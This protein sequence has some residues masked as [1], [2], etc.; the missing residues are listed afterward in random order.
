MAALDILWYGA[1]AMQQ[2][3]LPILVNGRRFHAPTITTLLI[4]FAA[5]AAGGCDPATPSSAPSRAPK[6]NDGVKLTLSCP[7]A[8]FAEAIEPMVRSW[9]AR[10]GAAVALSREPMKPD[11]ATDLAV[12]PAGAL[13][14]WA[15][16][17]QLAP[18]PPRLRNQVSDLL[19]PYAERLAAW[20]DQ[21]QAVP[22]T[23]DGVVLVFRADRFADPATAAEFQARAKRPLAPPATWDQFAA[24]A[25]FFAER[26]KKPSLPPLPADP[27]RLFDLVSRVAASSDRAAL[28]DKDLAERVKD[29]ELLAFHFSVKTGKPRLQSPGFAAAAKWLNALAAT[30]CLPPGASDDPAAA[31]G[32]GRAV[33]AVFSLDQ[34]AKLPRE[35]GAVPARFGIA[36][37]PGAIWG[38]EAGAKPKDDK[39]TVNYVP[40]FAGGRLGVVRAKCPHPEAAFDL[41]AEI[42][43]PA[44]SAELISTPGLGAGPLRPADLGPDL[45]PLWLG[46]G[47]D[48]ARSRALQ[49]ALRHYLSDT[50]KNPAFGLRGPDRDA[51]TLAASDAFR[52][53]GTGAKPT[54]VLGEAQLVWGSLDAK[55][56]D[57]AT[58]LRWRKRAAG[59]N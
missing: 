37:L 24:V 26:D 16:P 38:A 39:E 21:T 45:F 5:S 17:G 50:V 32:E 54:D 55:A 12:I 52:K 2:A 36:V 48:A 34:L 41:L 27:A 44:R 53:L 4:A 18:L 30:G 7:D 9:E 49:D 42:G 20:G 6:P 46:Y 11:D 19:P 1:P 22:L 28:S 29:E 25:A 58:Q 31:L 51:L 40:Y 33:M 23:G 56:A 3:L 8:A 59:V 57:P 10:T 13:G 15:E 35:N 14:A 43:G 47:F